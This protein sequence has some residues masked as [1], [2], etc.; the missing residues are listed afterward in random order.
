MPLQANLNITRSNINI[1]NVEL[2]TASI[3]TL[4]FATNGSVMFFIVYIT[5]RYR[6]I[7]NVRRTKSQNLNVAR[8]VCVIYWSQVLSREWIGAALVC[9]APTTT[10]DQQFYWL[11]RWVWLI[12]SYCYFLHAQ[13]WAHYIASSPR[14]TTIVIAIALCHILTTGMYG[15][16]CHVFLWYAKIKSLAPND[17]SRASLANTTWIE[18]NTNSMYRIC[19]YIYR[20]RKAYVS[21]HTRMI[22]LIREC[23]KNHNVIF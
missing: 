10:S 1:C 12:C 21:F 18:Q 23:N 5:G 2:K 8:L 14:I 13:W 20:E 7:S 11:L 15:E 16:N 19:I 3:H 6:Q 4:S 9:D 22:Y 17:M